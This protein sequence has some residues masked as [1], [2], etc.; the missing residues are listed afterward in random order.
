M[1]HAE[2]NFSR[3]FFG[4]SF[5]CIGSSGLGLNCRM[6]TL[7]IIPY[8]PPKI[9]LRICWTFGSW[10]DCIPWVGTW[11]HR[12]KYRQ[13]AGN[14]FLV[15]VY[16]TP[17]YLVPDRRCWREEVMGEAGTNYRCQALLH[18]F[19][20]SLCVEFT[21]EPF[22]NKPSYSTIESKCF[23]FGVN[24]IPSVPCWVQEKNFSTETETRF[25]RPCRRG[26]FETTIVVTVIIAKLLIA[27][28][29]T[30]I[31][32]QFSLPYK[33]TDQRRK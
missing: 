10:N 27:A 9:K 12:S 19:Y 20:L 30:N 3:A 29:I 31:W 4:H 33:F 32:L 28:F 22:Q 17:C 2:E 23:R 26:S 11:T 14:L 6:H 18:V 16:S 7:L 5:N 25:W 13:G 8:L 21:N 15:W 1:L 24:I